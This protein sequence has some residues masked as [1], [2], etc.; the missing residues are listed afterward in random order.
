MIIFGGRRGDKRLNDMYIWHISVPKASYKDCSLSQ[1][2]VGFNYYKTL[3][4]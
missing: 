4:Q 1:E 2:L 3:I